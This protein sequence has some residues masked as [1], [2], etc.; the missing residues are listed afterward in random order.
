LIWLEAAA[1]EQK[2]YNLYGAGLISGT[3]FEHLNLTMN[4]N[5][6]AVKERNSTQRPLASPHGS[7]VEAVLAAIVGRI[8][9]EQRSVQHRNRKLADE[10]EQYSD[11]VGKLVAMRFNRLRKT[12]I[13]PPR[14]TIVPRLTKLL[15]NV[16]RATA[17]LIQASTL[18]SST[19]EYS[20][21]ARLAEWGYEHK[22]VNHG[23]GNTPR[24]RREWVL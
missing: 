2:A 21:Y 24:R 7:A 15:S 17:P 5:R 9:P 11:H 22:K 18:H 19:D 6:D 23:Q 16:K 4:L 8:L 10:Y 3:V 1:I 12:V 20:I 14:L 13:Y